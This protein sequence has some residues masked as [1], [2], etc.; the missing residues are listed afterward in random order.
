MKHSMTKKHF[1]AMA[2]IIRMNKDKTTMDLVRCLTAYFETQ[3]PLFDR[4]RFNA[5]A[6]IGEYLDYQ[7][8]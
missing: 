5:E 8:S 4:K 6:G 1:V 2:R 7:N 3:N